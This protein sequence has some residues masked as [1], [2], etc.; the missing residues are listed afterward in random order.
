MYDIFVR[1]KYKKKQNP[2]ERRKREKERHAT[3]FFGRV[4]R[5]VLSLYSI[6]LMCCVLYYH[7][8]HIFTQYKKKISWNVK[9]NIIIIDSFVRRAIVHM[10]VVFNIYTFTLGI[11][12]ARDGRMGEMKNILRKWQWQALTKRPI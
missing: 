9:T 12:S 7:V 11:Q 4:G 1:C 5:C 8:F 6:E 2:Q 10:C 3:L